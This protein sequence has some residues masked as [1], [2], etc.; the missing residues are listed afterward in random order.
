M[1]LHFFVLYSTVAPK[2]IDSVVVLQHIL[3]QLGKSQLCLFFNST[4][5]NLNATS[6]L[7]DVITYYTEHNAPYDVIIYSFWFES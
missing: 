2:L 5:V 4:Q 7:G 3:N 6:L 1:K